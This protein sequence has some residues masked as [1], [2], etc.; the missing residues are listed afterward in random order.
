[1]SICHVE[2]LSKW[3]YVMWRNFS[4]WQIFSPRAPPVVPMTNMKYGNGSIRVDK[5]PRLRCWCWDECRDPL[6]AGVENVE[7]L[8]SV[9]WIWNFQCQAFVAVLYTSRLHWQEIVSLKSLDHLQNQNW[10]QGVLSQTFELRKYKLFQFFARNT[11]LL[12][13]LLYSSSWDSQ[14]LNC[15]TQLSTVA[16]EFRSWTLLLLSQQWAPSVGIIL[17]WHKSDQ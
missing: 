3:Q 15:I 8:K 6:R 11:K 14:V 7:A 10:K 17:Q 16:V 13:I 1:M 5:A 4:T 2:N 12:S 9:F